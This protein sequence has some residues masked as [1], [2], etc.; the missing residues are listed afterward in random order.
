MSLDAVWHDLECGAYD[1]DLPLWRALASGAR[2]PVLDV[3]A[4]T[5]RVSLDLAAG[6]AAVVALDAEASLL[7]ALEHRAAGLRVETVVADAR[8]FVLPR[9]FPL[10]LVPMQTLQL[11]DGPSGREA[12]LRRVLDH[13]EPG[14]LLAA[15]LADAMDCFDEEHDTPPPPAKCEID[16][17]RY[18]SQLIK[19]VDDNGRA[20]I[21]RRREVGGPGERYESREAIVRLDRVTAD[22][23]AAEA[24]ALGFLIEP[25][26]FIPGTEEYLG[27][28]VVVLRAPAT[29]RRQ[30]LHAQITG[31]QRGR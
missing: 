20:A 11:F 15:A 2:G 9:R 25:C 27:S 26:L 19:V 6:G 8:R 12:F 7:E 31:T 16:G 29:A 4:G 5:G 22:E 23:V 14:G 21:H 13:L 28:T 30:R 18:A 10:V 3:G 1:E 24:A 17:V